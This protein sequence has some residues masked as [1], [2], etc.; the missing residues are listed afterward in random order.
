M[1]TSQNVIVSGVIL[2]SQFK[3]RDRASIIVD[4]L[5]SIARDPK[6]TTKTSIMRRANLNFGQT[7][8]YLQHLLLSGL[9]REENPLGKQELCRYKLTSEGFKTVNRLDSLRDTFR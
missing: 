9:I 5:A 7:N 3:Y 1:Y 4:I 8:R 6:G 2:L